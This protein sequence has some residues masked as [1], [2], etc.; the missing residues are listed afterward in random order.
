[1]P[2]R[3]IH[4][5][6]KYHK[7]KIFKNKQGKRYI[8]VKGK[9]YFLESELSDSALLKIIEKFLLKTTRRRKR[10]GTTKKRLDTVGAIS[11][12]G[13]SN[14]Q[15][16]IQNVKKTDDAEIQ[17]IRS[18]LDELSKS[19]VVP[20]LGAPPIRP[21]LGAPVV[22]PPLLLAGPP[23]SEDDTTYETEIEREPGRIFLTPYAKDAI[24][25][26]EADVINTKSRLFEKE[27][28]LQKKKD[29][30]EKLNK[31]K[32]QLNRE[33]QATLADTEMDANTKEQD[34]K[35]MQAEFL[36]IEQQKQEAEQ[37]IH[38]LTQKT[39]EIVKKQRDDIKK[40][41]DQTFEAKKSVLL[42][43]LTEK[44][45]SE[46]LKNF[47]YPPG[48]LR[49]KQDTKV[50]QIINGRKKKIIRKKG[51][52]IV[53]EGLFDIMMNDIQYS[54]YLN[55]FVTDKFNPS[56]SKEIVQHNFRKIIQPKVLKNYKEKIIEPQVYRKEPGEERVIPKKGN[57]DYSDVDFDTNPPTSISKLIPRFVEPPSSIEKG[58]ET[59]Q[60]T[61]TEAE[62]EGP[63][64]PPPSGPP[65][66]PMIKKVLTEEEKK[67]L[68]KK[69]RIK[70]LEG[71]IVTFKKES[72]ERIKKFDT[73]WN[74]KLD[75]IH[76]LWKDKL[77][78]DLEDEAK[79]LSK[80]SGSKR[81]KN[82]EKV[83]KQLKEKYSKE[84]EKA[85]KAYEIKKVEEQQ[86]FEKT[87][88]EIQS[89]FNQKHQ[90]TLN[91]IE[92]GEFDVSV[93]KDESSEDAKKLQQKALTEAVEKR[94]IRQEE[95]EA[96]EY[97]KKIAKEEAEQQPLIQF[98]IPIV[99][100]DESQTNS[101]VSDSGGAGKKE[102]GLFDYQINDYMQ[103]YKKN[104]FKGVYSSNEL[105]DIPVSP[106][107]SFIMLINYSHGSGHWVSVYI[108]SKGDKSIE[109]YDSYASDPPESF[110][111]N[112][113]LIIN[114]LNPATYLKFK[115]NKIID[116]RANSDTC[117][118][119]AMLWLQNRYKG[120]SF[121]DC[122]GY[123]DIKKQEKKANV[124]KHKF[125]RFGLI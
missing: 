49:Y 24:K 113:K 68:S 4:K 22:E 37:K 93:I 52:K 35:D 76:K 53:K 1:M 78:N 6:T 92:K 18:K 117:G 116:Q 67:E 19:H 63:S 64:P 118:Y 112:I 3:K 106:K 75:D 111:R 66:P 88:S 36:K 21:V 85:I 13:F 99:P 120:K 61:E 47:D 119:H 40:E 27:Q 121:K 107:M 58:S 59:E 114:K 29:E 115:V 69:N 101:Q 79:K 86:K 12:I 77:E 54:D 70:K 46:A 34:L 51:T 39:N 32:E 90:E 43:K 10:K 82:L 83:E 42:S 11:A 31:S 110:M 56:D 81:T 5:K 104:G 26:S 7:I 41:K 91:K 2:K 89:K 15:K 60:T 97:A 94:R 45:I 38:Q 123:S 98:D 8:K 71:D 30:L 124:M 28:E 16:E 122:T 103:Q 95:K 20:V 87:Q 74:K 105:D 23:G 55:Q 65:P 108:D 73:I 80:L 44:E 50:T 62:V 72:E 17:Q 14:L 33:Y 84:E 9:K 109:Y 57:I 102:G 96:E 48:D 125:E 100:L 25:R